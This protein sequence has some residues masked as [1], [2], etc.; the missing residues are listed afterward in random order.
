ML[1]LITR[2]VLVGS[3]AAL[4]LTA[5]AQD[6]LV[7]L[8][9]TEEHGQVLVGPNG[10]TLY[11]FTPD[12]LNGSVCAGQC[13][14]SWPPLTVESADEL[15]VGEGIPGTLNTFEREDGTLQ[16]A[17]NGLPLYYWFQDQAPGDTTGHGVNNIWWVVPPATVYAQPIAELGSTLVGPTGMTLY[18]FTNDTPGESSACYDQCATAWPPLTVE[19][20]EDIVAGP[21]LGE[22]GTIERTDGT[23]QV[24][25]NGWPLYYWQNDAAVGDATGEGRNDVWFTVAP[26][27][28]FVGNSEE[29][30]DFLVSPSGMTLYMFDND[31]DGVSNCSGDCASA[32]PPYIVF[33]DTRLAASEGVEGELGTTTRDNGMLQLTYNGMPLYFWQN[34]SLPGDTTGQGV[35]EVWWVV[36]P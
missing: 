17:Y 22:L 10:M 15:S 12:P 16:V 5:L 2:L 1:K 3:I 29:L 32:W 35:G 19:S 31:T 28:V 23:L 25:Y 7:T 21:N 6:P 11:S 4:G 26:E 24:T 14:V 30:G 36:A 20:A 27:V 8:G 18:T 33:E 9:E 13:A 34:D